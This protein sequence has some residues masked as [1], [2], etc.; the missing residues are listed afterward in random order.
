MRI[1]IAHSLSDAA[2][3]LRRTI[4]S[5]PGHEIAWMAKDGTD[6]VR[7]S[8][9]DTPDLLFMDLAIEGMGGAEAT[10]LIMQERPCA[11]LI[12]TSSAAEKA[13]RVFEAMGN[14]ALDVV[15]IPAVDS[16]GRLK[17]SAELLKKITT[18]EKLIGR[19]DG[20]GK[21]R[22]W[23]EGSTP[24]G[25]YP[26]V[27]IGS[28]TGG[29]KVLAEILS[30]LPKGL[31]ASIVIV[32]HLDVQFAQGLVEWL[33]EQTGHKVILAEAGSSPEENTVSV[34]GTNDHLILEAD[35]TFQ[36]VPEPRDYPYR[37]SVDRFFFSVRDYWPQKG[38]AVLLT[39]MGRDGAKGLLA[40][41]KEGWHTIAQNEKTSV[42]YGMP[43]AAAELGAA[44][45]ILPVE[46]VA[47]EISKEIARMKGIDKHGYRRK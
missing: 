46:E 15:D 45:K 44:V 30:R 10:R 40:L 36:Y 6:T 9:T 24:M 17:G 47:G 14:G 23:P 26:M 29:P 19:E 31:G 16:N 32:Q 33:S 8:V 18:I 37:P 43:K 12:V 1:A 38:V 20:Q 4:M 7:K 25:A 39:G 42:V 41:R 11:I 27:T 13:A 34:A 2:D 5:A 28:S 21:G 22:S 3:V 35:G